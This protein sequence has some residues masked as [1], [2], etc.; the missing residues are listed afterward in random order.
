MRARVRGSGG[1]VSHIHVR[2]LWP[3]PRRSENFAGA[4][5]GLRYAIETRIQ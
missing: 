3:L 5:K 4:V 2:H 1:F